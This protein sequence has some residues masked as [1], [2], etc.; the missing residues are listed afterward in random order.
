MIEPR[1]Q[2]RQLSTQASS[3]SK[4]YKQAIQASR[5]AFLGSS[6]SWHSWLCDQKPWML[7]HCWHAF[8]P[9][10][11]TLS[12]TESCLLPGGRLQSRHK[13]LTCRYSKWYGCCSSAA[14][15]TPLLQPLIGQLAEHSLSAYNVHAW[16][17]EETP[18]LSTTIHNS[19]PKVHLG[20][21]MRRCG[22]LR[23]C[24]VKCMVSLQRLAAGKQ[25][26]RPSPLCALLYVVVD[27]AEEPLDR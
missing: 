20:H 7:N 14:E 5:V 25:Q 16:P 15:T 17:C 6:N 8:E 27:Q 24:L 4:R 19:M 10:A 9:S 21:R 18:H 23:G 11:I 1:N 22:H 3:T 2:H 26:A 12:S 13:R